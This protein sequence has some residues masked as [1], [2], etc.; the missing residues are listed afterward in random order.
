MR[1]NHLDALLRE[2]FVKTITVLRLVADHT[3]RNFLGQHEIEKPLHKLA[4]VWAA[5]QIPIATAS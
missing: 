4:L 2:F 1:R 5:G 3:R